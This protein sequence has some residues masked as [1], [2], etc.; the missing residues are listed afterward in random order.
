MTLSLANN[1]LL[2][3][4]I[5][6]VGLFSPHLTAAQATNVPAL[7]ILNSYHNGYSW[8]DVECETIRNAVAAYDK[9]LPV[10]VEYLDTKRQP[11]TRLLNALRDFLQL[12]YARI[13]ISVLIACDNAALEFAL[14]YR[15]AIAPGTPIVFCG[16][17]G[18]QPEMIEDHPDVFGVIEITWAREI[19]DAAL[20]LCPWIKN[21]FIINDY[22]ETGRA[23]DQAFRTI[24]PDYADRLTFHYA[25]NLPASELLSQLTYLGEDTAVLL[26]VFLVDADGRFYDAAETGKMVREHCPVPLFN[27]SETHFWGGG[28]GGAMNSPV[29]QGEGAAQLAIR[30]LQGEPLDT[31]PPPAPGTYR[32]IFDALELDA[33]NLSPANLPSGSMLINTPASICN[34]YPELV[35][36][37]FCSFLILLSLLF[38]LLRNGIKRRKAEREL[39]RHRQHLEHLVI[40]RTQKLESARARLEQRAS[41]LKRAS[42]YKSRF[43]AHISHEVR[44]PLNAIIGFAEIILYSKSIDFIHQQSQ[45]ILNETE[46]LLAIINQLLDHARIESGKIELEFQIFDLHQMFISLLKSLRHYALQK[47][48]DLDFHYA[49]VPHFVTGD[50]L[51]LRQVLLNLLTNAIKFT[52]TGSVTLQVRYLPDGTNPATFRFSVTDTGVGIPA[53]RLQAVFKQFSQA[54]RSTARKY[55][56]SGLG[57]TIAYGLVEL[58]GGHL[59]VESTEGTGSMFWFDVRLPIPEQVAPE[60]LAVLAPVHVSINAYPAHKPAHILIADDYPSNQSVVRI[61]L[62]N[63]GYTCRIADTGREAVNI[64]ELENFDLILMDISMPILDGYEATRLIRSTPSQNAK[65]PILALSA[66]AGDHVRQQCLEAGMNDIIIKPIHRASFLQQINHWLTINEIAPSIRIKSSDPS[67][68]RRTVDATLPIDYPLAIH[69]FANREDLVVEALQH[70]VNDVRQLLPEMKKAC[71]DLDA[72]YIM[73]EAHKIA[74]A[75]GNLRAMPLAFSAKQLE[76]LCQIGRPN[77]GEV[78]NFLSM[79]VDC[80]DDL[81]DYCKQNNIISI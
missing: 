45:T 73:K 37:V 34:Q 43:L 42:E 49:E 44:T 63:A 28:I 25:D 79:L 23:S 56:G 74:G 6:V 41:D 12:K 14:K 1:R 15:E 16:I 80:F 61:H 7:L 36:T 5:F 19:L 17:N 11:D 3:L 24:E 33:F 32:L 18:Y 60:K 52:D 51:R 72:A 31:L 78:M 69:E 50:P 4:F 75:A 57:T 58:M 54:D 40:E 21:I 81:T 2:I 9:K 65:V 47:G 22:T 68:P 53:D 20:S 76:E 48:L 8:S 27:T 67:A 10:Y 39:D 64:C 59:Q 46:H 13:P 77:P 38:F 66:H 55:G 26:D 30:I 35:W 29:T 70:F 62:Q 71:Q